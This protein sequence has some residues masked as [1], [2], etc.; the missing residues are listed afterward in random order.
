QDELFKADSKWKREVHFVAED[1]AVL[2]STLSY[3]DSDMQVNFDLPEGFSK[4]KQYAMQ[5]VNVPVRESTAIDSNVEKTEKDMSAGESEIIVTTQKAEGVLEQ[6]E[7][8]VIYS[9]NLKSSQ[10]ETF[11][12]KVDAMKYSNMFKRSYFSNSGAEF[13]GLREIGTAYYTDE[14]FSE[15]ELDIN[16]PLVVF[17]EALQSKWYKDKI[18][19]EMYELAQDLGLEHRFRDPEIMGYVPFKKVVVLRQ[20]NGKFRISD[21]IN[22][23][24]KDDYT[25]FEN[26]AAALWNN[27]GKA[28][29]KK[30][31]EM[32]RVPD[33]RAGEYPVKV[34]Y[35]LPGSNEVTSSKTIN[36]K[37]I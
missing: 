3:S 17:E 37:S 27:Q 12:E 16:R 24:A 13:T 15:R 19:P 26:Q 28:K 23:E 6:L 25:D 32:E 11:G 31:L 10:Y 35:V 1:G 36:I 34:K 9:M 2:K 8:K 18:Y 21:Q 29:A 7:E 20:L 30:L 22:W 14:Y 4:Q 33:Y 5:L